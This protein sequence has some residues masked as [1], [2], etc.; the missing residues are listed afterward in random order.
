[1]TIVFLLD[2]LDLLQNEDADDGSQ[3]G[4]AAAAEDIVTK[5][6]TS[7]HDN[8]SYGSISGSVP[9]PSAGKEAGYQTS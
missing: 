5:Q 6:P 9:P 3:E 1:M 7:S 4:T 2:W 8:R